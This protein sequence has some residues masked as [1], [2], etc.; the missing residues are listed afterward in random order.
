MFRNINVLKYILPI[1]SIILSLIIIGV[2]ESAE[3]KEELNYDF[4]TQNNQITYDMFEQEKNISCDYNCAP[5]IKIS[6]N[7]QISKSPNSNKTTV[8][9]SNPSKYYNTKPNQVIQRRSGAGIFRRK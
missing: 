5:N 6:E 3:P 2:C 7:K 1:L 8:N 9:R 4:N